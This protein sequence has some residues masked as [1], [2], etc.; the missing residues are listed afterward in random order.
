M[1]DIALQSLAKLQV[2]AQSL[3]DRLSEEEGQGSVEYVGVVIA[4]A[5]IVLVIIGAA[6]GL[7][8]QL[9]SGLSRRIG[10]IA[11]K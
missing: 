6:S 3:S 5:L 8:G 10:E 9:L 4:A 2:F 11:G 1:S 7:G